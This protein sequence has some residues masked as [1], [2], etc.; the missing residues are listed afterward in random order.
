M[1][2]FIDCVMVL[3]LVGFLAFLALLTYAGVTYEEKDVPVTVTCIGDYKVFE[4]GDQF[5][6]LFSEE[7]ERRNVRPPLLGA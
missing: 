5:D 2:K 3:F 7:C 6:V 1:S 4:R